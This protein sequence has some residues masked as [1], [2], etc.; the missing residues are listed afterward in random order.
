MRRTTGQLIAPR[1]FEAS[2]R[3]FV[4]C[5]DICSVGAVAELRILSGFYMMRRAK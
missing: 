1:G 5:G 4:C 2:M 3:V